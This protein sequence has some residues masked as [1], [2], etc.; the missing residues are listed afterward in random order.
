MLNSYSVVFSG[1]TVDGFP[2]QQVKE[3]LGRLFKLEAGQLERIFSG[4][5]VALKKGLQKAE[6][7]KLRNSLAKAG[8]LGVIKELA[9][10]APAGSGA[11][12]TAA[13]TAVTPEAIAR[14]AVA[15]K[16]K[17][18]LDNKKAAPA[19]KPITCPRCGFDQPHSSS[20]RHCKMDLTLH[21]RRVAKR[22][23]V[24]ANILQQRD[25]R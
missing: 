10:K 24:L 21:F 11:A 7:L 13:P 20:C 22:E 3:N 12:K 4:K 9:V 6:A 19:L 23:K 8:A 5:P 16:E 2:L 1:K 15:S 17:G 14:K 25:K 18:P